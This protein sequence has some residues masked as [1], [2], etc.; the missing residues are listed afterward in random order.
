MGVVFTINEDLV[1]ENNLHHKI[2]IHNR[3]SKL[4]VKGGEDQELT[5]INIYAPNDEERKI[6]IFEKLAS[7]TRNNKQKDLCVIGDFNCV[8]DDTDRSPH[9]KAMGRYWPP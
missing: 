3:A 7:M 5:P 8:E 4:K 1:D 6:K 9:T 2:M